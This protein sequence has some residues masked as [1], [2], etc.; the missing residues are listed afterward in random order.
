MAK[1]CLCARC[2]RCLG[3]FL[4][5]VSRK[6]P[7]HKNTWPI[8]VSTQHTGCGAAAQSHTRGLP[9]GLLTRQAEHYALP[10]QVCHV[11]TLW[12]CFFCSVLMLTCLN[13]SPLRVPQTRS[14]LL[15]LTRCL[16]GVL[17]GLPLTS[18]PLSSHSASSD[19]L[20]S[21]TR[22]VAR[23]GL[24]SFFLFA[25]S[26]SLSGLCVHEATRTSWT[27]SSLLLLIGLAALCWEKN[28]GTSQ[29]HNKMV[30]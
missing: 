29:V 11:A 16:S 5:S 18:V 30:C 10:L 15:M 20:V 3:N 21:S 13:S 12:V 8:R 19:P 9:K 27:R 24:A 22:P 4:Q 6:S 28:G 26:P 1:L 25:S 7:E 23:P 17:A 14:G 2:C